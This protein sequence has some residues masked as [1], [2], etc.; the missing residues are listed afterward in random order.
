MEN[1]FLNFLKNNNIVFFSLSEKITIKLNKDGEEITSPAHTQI[2][3]TIL[4]R[5]NHDKNP[6]KFTELLEFIIEYTNALVANK[7]NM[8]VYLDPKPA[9]F[10][11]IEG[12]I[13]IID[14]DPQFFYKIN[15]MPQSEY[16]KHDSLLLAVIMISLY[17]GLPHEGEKYTEF[18]MCRK[19]TRGELELLQT[20][21]ITRASAIKSFEPDSPELYKY[22]DN[23][24]RTWLFKNG[25][26]ELTKKAV[27]NPNYMLRYYG[28]PQDKAPVMEI[29]VE[30]FVETLDAIGLIDIE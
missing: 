25:F 9:N 18:Q 20:N 26:K 23:Y 12:K 29:S 8:W 1:K 7:S 14:C 17:S 6:E 27:F 3:G 19:L 15:D 4:T 22:Y 2:K 10:A 16:Y 28:C 13:K 5:I 11:E 21:G 24:A 30:S